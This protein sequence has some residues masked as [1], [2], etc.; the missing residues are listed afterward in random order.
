MSMLENSDF[1]GIWLITLQGQDE[2][3]LTDV[4]ERA[5]K[6]YLRKLLGDSLYADFV[7][8]LTNDPVPEK[9]SNLLNGSTYTYDNENHVFQGLKT[10][11]K[12]FTRKD[13]F[14]TKRVIIAPT[15]QGTK[16]M[17][18]GVDIT[19]EGFSDV[20]MEQLNRGIAIYNEAI[21]FITRTNSETP[22]TYEDFAGEYLTLKQIGLDLT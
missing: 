5:E 2:T 6:D 15:G 3:L 11:L 1:N 19:S 22:D 13:Y 8:G 20:Q 10:M 14:D 9:W 7:S 4:I 12:Y 18:L 21:D 17:E 16:A